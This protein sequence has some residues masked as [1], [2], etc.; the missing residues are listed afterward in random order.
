MVSAKEDL[1]AAIPPAVEGLLRVHNHLIASVS[2]SLAQSGGVMSTK[3]L[4]ADTHA[5]SLIGKQ[6]ATIK[7]I[8]DT[9]KCTVRVLGSGEFTSL[10]CVSIFNFF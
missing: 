3:F 9:S 7:L 6:G 4:V 1:D 10:I 8:Q 5:G 2:D